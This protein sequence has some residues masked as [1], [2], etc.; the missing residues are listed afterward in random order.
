MPLG[1]GLGVT[2]G[3][4]PP[5]GRVAMTAGHGFTTGAP[6]RISA[7]ADAY[8]AELRADAVIRKP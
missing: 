7:A 2:G 8:L 4:K 3:C 6:A 5:V 1:I